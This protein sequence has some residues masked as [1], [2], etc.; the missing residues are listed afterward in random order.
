MRTSRN[1]GFLLLG[2]PW[3]LAQSLLRPERAAVAR[4]VAGAPPTSASADDLWHTRKLRRLFEKGIGKSR[5]SGRRTVR[6]E[7]TAMTAIPAKV[8]AVGKQADKHR[9]VVRI[10]LRKYRGSFNTLKFGENK[11]L[12]GSCHEGR[13]DLIYGRDPGFKEGQMFPLW[14]IQ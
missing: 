11:P 5:G 13:L 2:A 14:T 3:R 4:H 9:I 10:A 7:R 6:I 12:M 8:L 1:F